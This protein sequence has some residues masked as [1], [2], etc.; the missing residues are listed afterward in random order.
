M[1]KTAYDDMPATVSECL[2]LANVQEHVARAADWGADLQ[3]SVVWK[4]TGW[5][6]RT[7]GLMSPLEVIFYAYWQ[8]AIVGEAFGSELHVRGQHEVVVADRRYRLDFS[9][10]HASIGPLSIA[11]ELDGHAFHE[12]TAEQVALRN[13]RDRDLQAAGWTVCHFS[14]SEL[15]TDPKGT[16]G[17]VLDLARKAALRRLAAAE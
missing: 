13:T 7:F 5:G 2:A 14:G 15:L 11:V 17:A 12:R 8:A 10:E 16:V 1:S 6:A 9:V 4:A 3:R